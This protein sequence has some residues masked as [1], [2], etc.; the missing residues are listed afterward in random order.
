[1]HH[2]LAGYYAMVMTNI[3]E[4]IL[5]TSIAR[6]FDPARNMVSLVAVQP[7]HPEGILLMPQ[8]QNGDNNF[9]EY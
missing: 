5:P 7:L 9:K 1:M 2:S 8:N 4:S 3:D 6:L